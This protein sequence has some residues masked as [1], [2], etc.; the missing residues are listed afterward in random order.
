MTRKDFYRKC[1]WLPVLLPV[2]L[3]PVSILLGIVVH[4]VFGVIGAL[5]GFSLFGAI[6]YVVIMVPLWHYWLRHKDA[7]ALARL[8]W[9]LP[10]L[11]IPYV[12]LISTIFIIYAIADTPSHAQTPRFWETFPGA[13]AAL[14]GIYLVYA[15]FYVL[16]T[17]GLCKRA[18]KK[19]RVTD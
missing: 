1:L 2:V 7:D 4:S 16:L 8:S 12:V 15:Y 14:V 6:P 5:F 10:L 11:L 18:R 3:V 13:A 19:G 9:V 17:H